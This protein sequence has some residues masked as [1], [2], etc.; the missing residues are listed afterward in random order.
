L[1][2]SD[3]PNGKIDGFARLGVASG[4]FNMFDSFASTGL[5]FTGWVP[6]RDEDEFGIAVAAAFT[7]E[8]WRMLTGAAPAEVA[9]EATY[10]A[11]LTPWLAVQPN[12]HYIRRPAA[13]PAIDDAVVFGIRTEI[14]VD[15]LGG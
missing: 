12:A 8:P 7:S 2:F 3:Q 14:S 4:R 6:G 13:D 5:K 1:P 9:F 10:R 11:Q 15:L